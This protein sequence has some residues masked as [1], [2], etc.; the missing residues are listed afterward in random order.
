MRAIRPILQDRPNIFEMFS[1]LC[2]KAADPNPIPLKGE[3]KMKEKLICA[4]LLSAICTHSALAETVFFSNFDSS[5][6][7]EIAPGTAL[8]SG[9]EGY[10]GLGPVGNQFGGSFLRSET[11]NTVTLTLSGLPVHN[12]VNIGVLFAAIDSLDG[13][14]SY[15]SGDFLRINIDGNTVFRESF[16]NAVESQIQSYIPPSGV[17]LARHANLGFGGPGG[18]YTDSAYN[19]GA[20]PRFNGFAHT[21]STLTISFLIEGEGIQALS[22]ESWA[23]DNLRVEVNAVPVP[24][25]V[26][27]FGSGLMGLIGIVRGRRVG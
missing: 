21:A 5:L 10:A 26:W 23:M 14:G 1:V 6:P 2:S 20:D 11:G 9:V 19:L 12:S 25:A 16:A 18:Y 24:G 4:A 7:S 27:L 17:E 13:T 3:T 15:P 8:L 22:D